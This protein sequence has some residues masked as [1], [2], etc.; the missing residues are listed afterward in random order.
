[1]SEEIF[2]N[3]TQPFIL[4]F[5]TLQYLR[6]HFKGFL[7]YSVG[8]ILSVNLFREKERERERRKRRIER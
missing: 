4:H 6:I 5:T 3:K 2:S 8:A 1:M 7:K